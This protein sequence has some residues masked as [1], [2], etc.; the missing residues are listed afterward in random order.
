[1]GG[2]TASELEDLGEKIKKTVFELHGVQLE[3]E[4]KVVGK[5]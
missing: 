4:I 5:R 3:W 1:M 2:A